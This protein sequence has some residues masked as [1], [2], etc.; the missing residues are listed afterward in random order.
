M[1]ELHFLIS[2]AS[3]PVL[4]NIIENTLKKHDCTVEDAV[5]A[6][7]VKDICQLNPFCTALA[8]DGPLGTRYKRN[9]FL[10]EQLSFTEP[11]E[12]ILDSSKKKTF[13]YVP[14]LRLL[15]QLLNTKNIQETILQNQKQSNASNV[16]R[17]LHDGSV[18]KENEF[19]SGE[20]LRLPLILYTDDFEVCNP[21][22]TSRKKHK[23]TAV[24]WVFA[25]IPATLRSTLNSIHLAILCKADDVKQYG[26]P[27]VL[28]PLLKDLKTFENEGI[29]VSSLGKV[30]KGTVFA[31]VA[32]NLGAHCIGGFVESFSSSH[33]CRFCI[34]DR[35]QIQEYEVRTG[36][37]PLRTKDSYMDHVEAA[38]SGTTEGHHCGV[39]RLCPL[40]E[41]LSHF[42]AVSGYPPDA[43]H[44][45][46]EG[47][48]P[49]ELALCLEELM[50][51]KYFSL[52]LLNDAICQFPYK[53]NDKT[54]S[55]HAIPLTF[56]SRMS[57]G[58]N[59]HENWCLLRLLPL[60]IGDKVPEDD[61]AWQVLMTLKDVVELIMAP[62]HTDETLGYMDSK[63][64][65]HR[66]RYLNAFPGKKLKPKHHFLEHYP[67]LVTAFGP[68][69]ALWTMRFEAKHRFFKRLVR[70]SGSFK[71][72][73]MT[74]AQ[75]HQSM[76]A[77]H[78][79]DTVRP[80]VSVSRTTEV[81]VEILKDN[82]KE[83]FSKKFPR[84]E[85]VSVTNKITIFGTIYNAGMLLAFGSTGGLPD[86]GEIIQILIV[87]KNPVFVLK[88]LRGCYHEHLRSFKVEPTGEIGIS[89]HAELTD[90][91]PLAAYNTRNGRMVSLKHFIYI[92]E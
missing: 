22:G 25:D 71:N 39:K 85:V 42:H 54:N 6:E 70:Q 50:R 76:I 56:S 13:Q 35:S 79:Q 47:V 60:I 74:M 49:F 34:G 40:T 30:V 33:Y 78:I 44:D 80:M 63:I 21:L 83:S 61:E 26:Y 73:L 43:L 69:V 84:A 18:F 27:K 87:D 48:V 36:M 89:Q 57:V 5:V 16:Y 75:K 68:L 51:K 58:G 8:V 29:F 37:F 67:W 9:Q 14:V 72:I 90:A 45:L 15:S 53:W 2:S 3:E 19:F 7:L 82:I 91:Y 81:A 12:F 31:V 66:Y 4:K 38:L 24:Y 86:F 77:Y 32:D 23:V 28:E 55:P 11:V 1:E 65:E 64:S 41:Q 59:A 62:V 20:E 17:S 46:L 52:Q 10:K 92:S 88:L